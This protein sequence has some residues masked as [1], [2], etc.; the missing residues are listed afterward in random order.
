MDGSERIDPFPTPRF[1]S[2]QPSAPGDAALA[3]PDLSVAFLLIFALVF[4]VWLAYS[5]V[6]AYHLFRYGHRS[7]L[8]VPMLGLHVIVSGGLM[9]L[10]L[11]GL[12]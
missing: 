1:F 2:V 3:M 10:A 7:L 6:V 9:L 4:L 12:G 8:A 11:S 5:V